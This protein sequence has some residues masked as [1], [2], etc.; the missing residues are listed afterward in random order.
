MIKGR[1]FLIITGVILF[2]LSLICLD[3]TDL[4]WRANSGSYIGML[5]MG[6]LIISMIASIVY[7]RRNKGNFIDE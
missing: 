1:K 2:V 7:E 5:A 6:C 4:S 3:F